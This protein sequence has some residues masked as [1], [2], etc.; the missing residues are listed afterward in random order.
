MV[1]TYVIATPRLPARTRAQ[2][3][4]G[5]VMVWDTERP[6]HYLRWTPDH[7]LLFGGARPPALPRAVRAAGA[8]RQAARADRA[9]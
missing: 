4:L 7:R 2:L 5:D 8:A 9:I 1:N 6:Y 3:G